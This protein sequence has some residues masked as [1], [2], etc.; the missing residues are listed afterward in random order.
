MHWAII[1]CAFSAYVLGKLLIIRKIADSL[2]G[3]QVIEKIQYATYKKHF[4]QNNAI[5]KKHFCIFAAENHVSK[6]Q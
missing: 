5:Y 4:L 1:F 2:N 3:T 6:Y